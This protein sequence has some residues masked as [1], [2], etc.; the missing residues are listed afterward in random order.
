MKYATLLVLCS[1][2]MSAKSCNYNPEGTHP[3]FIYPKK[4]LASKYTIVNKCPIQVSEPETQNLQDSYDVLVCYTP[5]ES[6]EIRR[7]YESECK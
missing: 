6:A 3:I 5:E 1:F 7:E 4:N 2:L